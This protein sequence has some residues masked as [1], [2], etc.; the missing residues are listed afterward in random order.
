M[1][2][3][4]TIIIAVVVLAMTAGV[5]AETRIPSYLCP[6]V[7]I[8]PEIDGKLDDAAW[9]LAPE[10]PL[11]ISCTAEQVTKRTVARMCWDDQ[12]FYIAFDC[13]DPDI[14]ATYT[15]HDDPLYREEVVEAFINP[16][17]DTMHY[18]EIN[19]SPRNVIF[20]AYIVNRNEEPADG[21]DFGWTCQGM[22]TAVQ[23]DGT[24]D[25]RTDVDRGWTAE[26]AI[27]FSALNRCTPKP[28]ERWR[29]NLYR[30]DLEPEP[31]EFQA[32]SPTMTPR[33]KFHVPARFG[34]VFFT[35]GA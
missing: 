3:V 32:W 10:A 11:V 35:G 13:A 31:K 30:I 28:G 18:Y 14:F 5:G 34:T 33:P 2:L 27:P 16:S 21:T 15:Q 29:V 25:D 20:D 19:L 4:H 26:L 17:C 22:R 8:P 24:L 6:K 23:L 12:Y 7:S 1:N 9:K